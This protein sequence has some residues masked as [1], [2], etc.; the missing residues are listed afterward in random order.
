MSRWVVKFAA[1]L[2]SA[3][4]CREKKLGIELGQEMW[5][6]T[7]CSV[8]KPVRPKAWSCYHSLMTG[9]FSTT[10]G[11]LCLITPLITFIPFTQRVCLLFKNY[12]FNTGIGSKLPPLSPCWQRRGEACVLYSSS[13][14]NKF[15][16]YILIVKTPARKLLQFV[17]L[18]WC[19]HRLK[20]IPTLVGN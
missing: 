4:F 16:D 20:C 17:C 7:L 13:S 11:H 9:L 3:A 10:V 12:Y 15:D 19:W 18:N 8:M 14:L 5:I 1:T 6:K 2:S